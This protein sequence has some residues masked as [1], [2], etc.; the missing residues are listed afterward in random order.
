MS[1]R[2]QRTLSVIVLQ[3]SFGEKKSG[4]RF[5]RPAWK[6]VWAIRRPLMTRPGSMRSWRTRAPL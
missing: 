2:S 3:A 1:Y 5:T 4:K 6:N